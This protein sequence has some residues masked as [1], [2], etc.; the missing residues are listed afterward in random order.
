MYSIDQGSF[1]DVSRLPGKAC[2]F[3][4]IFLRLKLRRL[5]EFKRVYAEKP[6][7][8]SRADVFLESLESAQQLPFTEAH[9]HS[10]QCSEWP[11]GKKSPEGCPR[12]RR[13]ESL[14]FER[15]ARPGARTK[16]GH[17]QN[18]AAYPPVG[19]PPVP[20][21]LPALR[22][23]IALLPTAH[24]VKVGLYDL[25]DGIGFKV[26]GENLKPANRQGE[27]GGPLRCKS[28]C[29][30]TAPEEGEASILPREPNTP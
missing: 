30:T 17:E 1:Y 8:R 13:A 27:H 19:T 21:L 10:N 18:T 24:Q 26:V 9:C 15:H 4:D 20:C 12:L 5:E 23:R 7:L 16:E 22:G 3:P 28:T 29:L 6:L 11:G 25:W 14:R 2:C